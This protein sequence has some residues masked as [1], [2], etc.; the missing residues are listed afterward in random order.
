M[1]TFDHVRWHKGIPGDRAGTHIAMFLGWAITREL[2][3]AAHREDPSAAWYAA[4]VRSRERTARDFLIDLCRNRLTEADLAPEAAEFATTYYSRYLQD[5]ARVFPEAASI[6]DVAETWENFDR[7]A[8]ILDRRLAQ[9][10]RWRAQHGTPVTGP[11]RAVGTQPPPMAERTPMP[12]PL[13]PSPAPAPSATDNDP[14]QRTGEVAPPPDDD[15]VE[16]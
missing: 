15:T 1:G 13:R 14:T 3:A 8:T 2:I 5:Y 12:L 16:T 4:R 7:I 9:F 6:Y 10:R 11:T